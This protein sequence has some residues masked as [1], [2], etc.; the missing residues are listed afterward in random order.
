MKEF[1]IKI[2]IK[3]QAEDMGDAFGEL[4]TLATNR[5]NMIGADE[6]FTPD[7]EPVFTGEI[8]I[9]PTEQENP[10]TGEVFTNQ[11]GILS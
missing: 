7:P 3:L 6:D 1:R 5:A 4:A 2:N 10:L 8:D 11:R 9:H